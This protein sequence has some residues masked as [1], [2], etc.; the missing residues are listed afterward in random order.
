MVT[1]YAEKWGLNPKFY[2]RQ[3]NQESGYQQNVV[4]NANAIGIAQIIPSTAKA[5][6]ANPWDPHSA[7]NASARNM[8]SY[9]RTFKRAG[10]SDDVAHA[11][12]LSMYNSGKPYAYLNPRYSKGQT[13]HYIPL[14][15]GYR[16]IP[17]KKPTITQRPKTQLATAPTP[18]GD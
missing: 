6:K 2:H 3:I 4:S 14:I 5:W 15:M 8:A 13:Y 17:P 11:K 18:G 7:L 9:V 1:Y 16:P 12:A 10:D